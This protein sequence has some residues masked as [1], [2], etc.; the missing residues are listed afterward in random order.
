MLWPRTWGLKPVMAL[1]PVVQARGPSAARLAASM[2]VVVAISVQES[3]SVCCRFPYLPPQPFAASLRLPQQALALQEVRKL[4]PATS[5]PGIPQF[6][7]ANPTPPSI[8]GKLWTRRIFGG[9]LAQPGSTKA[10]LAPIPE[11]SWPGPP[12]KDR[13]R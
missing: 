6:V 1:L 2:L 12:E 9:K 7:A 10:N 13:T 5:R 11:G 4:P 8:D 3:N